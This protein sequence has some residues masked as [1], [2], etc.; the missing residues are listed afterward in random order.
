M[1]TLH[2]HERSNSVEINQIERVIE[3]ERKRN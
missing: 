2:P 1:K 3:R